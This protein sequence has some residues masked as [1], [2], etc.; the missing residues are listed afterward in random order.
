MILDKV[1]FGVLDQG[2]GCLLVFDEPAEDVSGRVTPSKKEREPRALIR[3]TM[4]GTY[5]ASLE[6]I[7]HI[8]NVVESLY[9]K[10]SWSR[11]H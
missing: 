7:E 2:A 4:Q 9:E 3:R 10:V 11:D 8:G 6:T 5:A 1:F